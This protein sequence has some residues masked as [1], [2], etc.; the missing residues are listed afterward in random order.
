MEAYISKAYILDELRI[1]IR[2]RNEGFDG[3]VHDKVERCVLEAAFGA[4]GQG[5]ANS[6]SNDDVIGI[7]LCAVSTISPGYA[8]GLPERG[9]SLKLTWW[10][11][12]IW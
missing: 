3:L 5:C 12:Q 7:F 1:D 9:D 11:D 2:F 4:F 6:T 10:R 8:S